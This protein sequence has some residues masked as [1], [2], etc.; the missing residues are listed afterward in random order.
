MIISRESW[1]FR[2]IRFSGLDPW[3]RSLCPYMRRLFASFFVVGVML[4]LAA[5][6]G[7]IMGHAL[8]VHVGVIPA[9]PDD[10]GRM[11][12]VIIATIMWLGLGMATVVGA[13]AW[14]VHWNDSRYQKRLYEWQDMCDARHRKFARTCHKYTLPP[15]PLRW[16]DRIK[17]KK[18]AWHKLWAVRKVNSN[19]PYLLR[20]Y[21]RA[22]HDKTCP[23]IDI[24]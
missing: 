5:I 19:L 22:L 8:G 4:C 2:F 15:Q 21:L 12:L 11:A 17:P 18:F 14:A 20:R 24:K 7:A 9:P 10:S 1:H 16:R 6:G 3:Q 23:M 13:F